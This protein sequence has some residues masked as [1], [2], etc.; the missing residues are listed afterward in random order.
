MWVYIDSKSGGR[1]V[2]LVVYPRMTAI[3]MVGIVLKEI[4]NPLELETHVLHEVVLQ[5]HLERPIHYKEVVF[6]TTLKWGTWPEQ[7]RRDNYLLLKKIN[8]FYEEAL[9]Y[10]VPPVSV[11]GE[12]RFGGNSKKKQLSGFKKYHFS[13]R[14]VVFW[15]VTAN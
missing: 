13:I 1:C 8:P 3:E 4:G 10:A 5:G 9:P 2:Q 12:A 14:Y 11:F 6:E 15:N 7:D